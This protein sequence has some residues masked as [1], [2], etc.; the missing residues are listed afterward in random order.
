VWP[1]LGSR[2]QATGKGLRS[3]VIFTSSDGSAREYRTQ[4][5]A[6]MNGAHIGVAAPGDLHANGRGA[7][8]WL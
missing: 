8:D 2:W 3:S 5:H 4:V 7:F 1:T 6:G